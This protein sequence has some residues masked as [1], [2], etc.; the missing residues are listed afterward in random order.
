MRIMI[1]SPALLSPL[2]PWPHYP[3]HQ[4]CSKS[5]SGKCHIKSLSFVQL[6]RLKNLFHLSL[7]VKVV[8][9]SKLQRVARGR[10]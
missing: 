5:V 1:G 8:S 7:V 4:H 6:S 3:S 9:A 2:G 10:S